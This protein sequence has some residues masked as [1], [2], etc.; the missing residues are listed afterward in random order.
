MNGARYRMRLSVRER[1]ILGALCEGETPTQIAERLTLSRR[2]VWNHAE[3]ARIKLG[4]AT[5]AAATYQ[6][7]LRYKEGL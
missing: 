2:T 7:A 3:N 5:T 1:E 6:Y 4:A